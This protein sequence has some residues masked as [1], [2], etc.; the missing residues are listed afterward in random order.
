MLSEIRR[1]PDTFPFPFLILIS[2]G[3]ANV[4]MKGGSAMEETKRIASLFKM[5]GIQSTV[6]DTETGGIR[7]G[8][9]Q[10]ISDA[11]EAKYLKLEELES[12]SIVDAVKYSIA[13]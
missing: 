9:A 11:M 2:D 5:D 3:K 13:G 4:S 10:Q 7:F 8:F 6:I 12:D 1:D